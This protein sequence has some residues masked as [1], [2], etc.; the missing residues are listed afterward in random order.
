MGY[1]RVILTPW[2]PLAWQSLQ[3]LCDRQEVTRRLTPHPSSHSSSPLL[4]IHLIPPGWSP[5]PCWRLPEAL[6]SAT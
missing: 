6:G 4:T 5:T 1:C 3:N 2:F